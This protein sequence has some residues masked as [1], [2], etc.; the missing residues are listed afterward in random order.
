ML[1]IIL[2]G[3]IMAKLTLNN[4]GSRYG[5]IDALN[6]N[7][8]L[9]EAALENTL[10]R[11]GT[12]P[13]NMESD[14]DMDSNSIINVGN[15][16]TGSLAI[17]GALTIGGL[18]VSPG[19]V[20]YTGVVKQ[21]LV[22]TSGQTVFNLTS[23]TYSPFTNNLSVFVDG[24]YQNPSRYTE[25]SSTTVTFSEGLHVGA[26]VDFQ[27]FSL[28]ELG[29]TTDAINVTYTPLSGTTTTVAS[30]LSEHVSVKDFGAVGDG[31]TDDTAAVVA[32]SATNKAVFFPDGTYLLS[33]TVQPASMKWHG[34]GGA[35]VK[36]PGTTQLVAD[37]IAVDVRGLIFESDMTAAQYTDGVSAAAIS[38]AFDTPT[39]LDGSDAAYAGADF[40]HTKASN[41][42]TLSLAAL[43]GGTRRSMESDYIALNASDRYVVHAASQF[44][45]DTGNY[46]GLTI[47]T[48]DAGNNYLGDYDP[49]ASTEALHLTGAAKIKLRITI[50]RS[51]S[52]STTNGTT[53]IDLSKLKFFKLANDAATAN[54]ATGFDTETHWQVGTCNDPRIEGCTFR[55]MRRF[56]LSLASCNR[57][58]IKQNTVLRSWGGFGSTLS[59]DSV[60]SENVIDLRQLHTDGQI[61]NLK[62]LRHKGI[63]G[64]TSPYITINNNSIIGASWGIE[65]APQVS[66]KTIVC[67]NTIL[68]EHV[69]VSVEGGQGSV[70]SNNTIT[71]QAGWPTYGVELA[72][73][74][75]DADVNSNT[76]YCFDALDPVC[77]GVACSMATTSWK[78]GRI[79]DNKL[80]SPVG[81]FISGVGAS[82]TDI[83]VQN[84]TIEYSAAGI[85]QHYTGGEI[86]ANICKKIGS[87]FVTSLSI[88]NRA[89]STALSS[90][91]ITIANNV[92]EAGDEGGIY[93]AHDN[94]VIENNRLSASVVLPTLVEQVAGTSHYATNN[95]FF[96]ST[97]TAYGSKSGAGTA[98]SKDNR[99]I[100]GVAVKIGDVDERYNFTAVTTG[101]GSPAV[102]T[103]TFTLP[104]VS[105]LPGG[106]FLIRSRSFVGD[107]NHHVFG[108]FLLNTYDA[109]LLDANVVDQIGTTAT[110]SGSALVGSATLACSFAVS[111][112]VVTLTLTQSGGAAGSAG[113]HNI[114]VIV[115]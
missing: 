67:D 16:A 30:K 97:P 25:T 81:V 37:G 13:N 27:V 49:G 39:Y 79:S 31:V 35:I 11:D 24:V 34:S 78:R 5:S 111:T 2:V 95:V 88:G 55:Y 107:G 3:L 66:I 50:R 28:N 69:G 64:S 60:F 108:L 73:T 63:A 101:T 14:L 72:G 102:H 71:L 56:P 57:A 80:F 109:G 20:N 33:G 96:G 61:Y 112:K 94:A 62:F 91:L 19:T 75:V 90:R 92:I 29:G 106:S 9:I 103:V 40:T 98:R 43:S 38:T 17:S 7:S 12:G 8:D 110:S 114:E 74:H 26:V 32:A 99:T 18:P 47:R 42:L 105:S 44:L 77:Y 115:L 41:T 6:D 51:A 104:T 65:V 48:Y 82:A 21:T 93:C 23:V 113:S 59:S 1:L 86:S 54:L 85:F 22:A 84:N 46:A 100:A 76:I 4:I 45:V 87:V 10:S 68:A 58:V 53:T 70:V 52:C 15:I 89:I 36:L 83:A